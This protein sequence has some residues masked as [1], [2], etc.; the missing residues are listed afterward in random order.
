VLCLSAQA[1][2]QIVCSYVVELTY[3]Y[4][5]TRTRVELSGDPWPP[6]RKI[7]GNLTQV[8]GP[9][10]E[11]RRFVAPPSRGHFRRAAEFVG[12][13]CENTPSNKAWEPTLAGRLH[14]KTAYR[15]IL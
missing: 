15:R 9:T 3:V 6:Q 10:V 4:R 8:P 13:R 7:G 5:F 14:G 12:R 1:V 2:R 11:I